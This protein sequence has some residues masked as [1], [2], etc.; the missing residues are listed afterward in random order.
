[1]DFLGLRNLTDARGRGAR[2]VRRR[3]PGFEVERHAGRRRSDDVRHA[4]R[5]ASTG[6]RVPAGEPPGITGRVHG[7]M[8]PA[9]SIEDLTAVVALYRPGPMECIPRFHRL[10]GAPGARHLSSCPLL[11]PIL[12]VTYGCIVY[13]E[14]VIEIFRQLGRVLARAGG[15]DPPRHVEEERGRHH[16]RARRRSCTASR[17]RNIPGAVARGV[18]ER[19]ANEIYDE[20]LAF[21]EAT[22]ST[23][24]TPCPTP[25]CPYR[26]A[27][28]KRNYPHEYMAALLT[29]VLDNTPKRHGVHRRVPRAGHPPAAAGH[30]CVRR[31]LHRRGG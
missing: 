21:R 18:P 17:E 19:T 10:L 20:I 11:E 8:Q 28:M 30:Q 2:Q 14:Q 3:E 23:R 5:R 12:S 13:Q 16:G 22:P 29:S 9:Q 6:G 1:M 26:T 27:Y 4:G 31:R 24:R 7:G 15:H 25:S